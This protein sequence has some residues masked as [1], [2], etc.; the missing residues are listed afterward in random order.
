MLNQRTALATWQ[1][2]EPTP[3]QLR[4]DLILAALLAAGGVAT[5]E[6]TRSID[7]AAV[8]NERLLEAHL[9]TLA[10]VVPLAVRRARPISVMVTC[11]VV[12][13]GLGVRMPELAWS[14]IVQVALF[15][16]I[17]TAWAW[18]RQRRPLLLATVGV[19]LAILALLI[20]IL[21]TEDVAGSGAG[22]I[23]PALAE[24]TLALTVN[25]AYFAG[26]IAWGEVA[27][28]GARQRY[29]L[30]EAASALQREQSLNAA[31]AVADERLRIARDLHDVV[32][33]HISGLGIQA[34]AA[35]HVLD[36][37]PASARV[38]LGHIEE[39]SRAAV[40]E[41][42]QLVGLLRSGG[43]EVSDRRPQ[44]GLG[45]L[46]ELIE[47]LS[48]GGFT[49]NLRQIGSP[50]AVSETVSLSLYRT[51]QEALTNVR[52]HSTAAEA[53]V[54][55]RYLDGAEAAVEIE[56]LDR[57]LPTCAARA[58]RAPGYGLDGIRERA[59][60]HGGSAEIGPCEGE[61]FRVRVRV[62]VP[63]IAR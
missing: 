30:R 21:L 50:V 59:A 17:Y 9:W 36:R 42:H 37:D 24:A 13:F 16:S 10:M 12:F 8:L 57:G 11:S 53:E 27:R 41:M 1:R 61:G 22:F 55:L 43:R 2:E 46:A 20:Q 14:M 29:E 6:T 60:L 38:A 35:G 26:A 40:N 33:H 47:S 49:A 25:V 51:A 28:R 56:I 54:V 45:G 7:F 19:V 32:A 52:R 18:S 63:S 58:D 23:P 15:I 44:P 62:P 4:R 34:A 48:A 5:V 3:T 31:R 39:A